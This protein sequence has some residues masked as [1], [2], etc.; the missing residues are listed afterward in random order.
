MFKLEDQVRSVGNRARSR[1]K[2]SLCSEHLPTGLPSP[3]RVQMNGRLWLPCCVWNVF[4]GY[5]LIGVSLILNVSPQKKFVLVTCPRVSD[6]VRFV[7][8]D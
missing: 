4:L 1:L 5:V 2:K 8:N 7:G 3:Q 6:S